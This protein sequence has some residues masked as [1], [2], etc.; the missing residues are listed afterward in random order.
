MSKKLL[1]LLLA[2]VLVLAGASAVFA[3]KKEDLGKIL[4]FDRHLSI[5]Q[6]QSCASCH[7][8][9]TAGFADPLNQRLPEMFPVSV[10]SD[11]SLVGGRNAPPASYAMFSPPFHF[12]EDEE[13]WFGG[14]FWDGRAATLE[15]QAKGPF[16]NPV[17]MA[18]GTREAVIA[19]LQ[20]PANPN[21]TAY[22]ELFW[23]V[24]SINLAGN[25][26]VNYTYDKMAEAIAA[27]ERTS[28]FASFTSKFDAVMAGKEVFTADEAAGWE[29]FNRE[30]PLEDGTGAGQCFLCHPAPLFTDFSYDNL[31]IPKNTNALLKDNEPDL[32]LGA[33]IP[34]E[35]GKF[36]VSSLRNLS[37]TAPYGHNGFFAN[38]EEIVHFYNTR[39]DGTWPDPEVFDNVN[40]DELGNLGLT[41]EQEAQLVAFLKTLSDRVGAKSYPPKKLP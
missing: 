6:N 24:Y 4:Y 15:E 2:G 21:A 20:D 33:I 8:P 38:L 10:G 31:G 9:D 36:K 39:D 23:G 19:A 35:E 29:I 30:I 40:F 5:N 14:Q 37:L 22:Q 12:D 41:D 25:V 13:L 1:S 26:D 28:A 27:F 7:D 11:T 16:L 3:G 18:M 32:G 34:G 17:E